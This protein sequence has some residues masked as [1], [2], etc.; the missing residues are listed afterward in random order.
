G[1]GSHQGKAGRSR[2]RL[3]AGMS[4]LVCDTQ[5]PTARTG[6]ERRRNV[7]LP[8]VLSIGM[9]DAG[10]ALAGVAHVVVRKPREVI[11]ML[12][13]LHFNLLLVR[14][15]DCDASTWQMLSV[16]RQYWPG[17]RWVLLAGAECTDRDEILARSLGATS[18]TSDPRVVAE[19]AR[20]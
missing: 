3:V 19:L 5:R 6:G 16:V 15:A 10:D 7:R 8:N 17:L 2:S 12:R 9:A 18:V 20:G 4:E 14:A 11:D 1:S 13:V